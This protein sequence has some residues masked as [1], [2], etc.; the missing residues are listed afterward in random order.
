MPD[1]GLL[2]NLALALVAATIGG[3]IAVRLG[4]SPILGYILVGV[5]IGPYTPGPV[6]EPETVAALADIGL[7]FLLFGVGLQLSLREVLS[8]GRLAVVGGTT[9]VL[10]LLA[11]GYMV[12]LAVGFG[13]LE[14]LFFGSFVALSSTTV[15]A[16]VL[17]ERGEVGAEHGTI[18]LAWATVQDL[19]AI[20]LVVLLGGLS[21]AGETASELLIAVGRAVLFLAIVLPL[22]LRVLPWLFE[23]AALLRSR[24]VFVLSVV[25]MA[26]GTAYV[27]QLLGLSLA[28]GAFVAGLLVSESDISYQALGELGP[29]RDVFAGIFFVS[30]G[31]LVDPFFIVAALPLVLVAVGLVVVVKGAITVALVRLFGVPLRVSVLAGVALAQS[32]EF[33]FLLARIG[34]EVGVVGGEMFSLMLAAA[35]VS[36]VL[37]P[38]LLKLSPHALRWTGRRLADRGL[39]LADPPIEPASQRGRYVVICGF[40]RVGRPVGAA[41]EARGFSYTVVEDDP[42]IVRALRQRNVTVVQGSAEN[43]RILERAGVAEARVLVA[44]LH[45]AIAL[46]QVIDFARRVNPR[47]HIVARARTAQDREFLRRQGVQEIVTPETEAAL[48]MARFTLARLGVS[49]IETAAIVQGLRRR[50]GG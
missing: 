26:L 16:K 35:G 28:L 38:W 48:E 24:E 49:A 27:S 6:G 43:P 46:R 21:A 14:A 47:L 4:Q 33:S 13:S 36:I 17:A 32:G 30:V 8:V 34:V 39:A 41:L 9:Q 1:S 37:A 50:T 22:G 2:V 10:A 7:I 19:A 12:A 29:L 5:L 18:A 44:A 40:G 31:M 11:V 3:A 25:A 15:L 23:R 45:D 42:R 20:V